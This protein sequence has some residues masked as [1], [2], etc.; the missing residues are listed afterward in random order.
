VFYREL[1]EEH[2]GWHLWSICR[3][4]G[5]YVHT[6]TD[7]A[8]ANEMRLM[9]AIHQGWWGICWWIFIWQSNQH[10]LW[11]CANNWKLHQGDLNEEWSKGCCHN[12]S[13]CWGNENWWA[14]EI[15]ASV[16]VALPLSNAGAE[17]E[18][19]DKLMLVV[20]HGLMRGF[21]MTGFT[22]WTW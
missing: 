12:P 19:L 16:W 15:D 21:M 1:G 14:E 8:E 17:V 13:P 22:L 9:Q 18:D 5:Q 11:M 20:K 10:C 4:L 2:W 6:M 7:L 3:L